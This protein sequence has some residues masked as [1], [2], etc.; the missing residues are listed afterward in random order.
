MEERKLNQLEESGALLSDCEP[1]T[2]QGE[3]Y[4]SM[5]GRIERDLNGLVGDKL[6]AHQML[7][8]EDR[9][10]N[11]RLGLARGALESGPDSLTNAIYAYGQTCAL[12][13]MASVLGDLELIRATQR[14]GRS[15][16]ARVEVLLLDS[17][18]LAVAESLHGEEQE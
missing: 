5:L 18:A 12:V 13:G 10:F 14:L 17:G 16:G 8:A 7:F 2:P 11:I 4:V 1:E 3:E 6:K 15:I 9:L